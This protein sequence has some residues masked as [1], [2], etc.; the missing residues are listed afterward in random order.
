MREDALRV[1]A[2]VAAFT[3][4][5]VV[6]G[7]PMEQSGGPRPEWQDHRVFA[8]NKL[9]PR[10]TM[11]AYESEALARGGDPTASRW[12]LSLN[13]P[14]KFHWA[15]RPDDAPRGHE[16]EDFDDDAWAELP[17]PANWEV[18]GYGHAI[19]L[20]E[21]YPFQAEWP[22]V[23]VDHNP[24]GS[25]RRTFELDPAWEGD[26]VWLRFG[27]V[28]S[29]LY[30]WLNGRQVGYSQGAKTPAS[31]TTRSFPAE[32]PAPIRRARVPVLRTEKSAACSCSVRTCA[33]KPGGK[34][35]GS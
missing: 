34:G 16:A 31:A 20:D 9:A 4:A 26:R 7:Q 27:G 28:R 1:G 32:S 24:V 12:H 18:H 6:Q 10:A 15:A 21:R 3:A 35:F 2:L 23:P 22:R 14:W 5:T 29:A 30:V 19:Y 11:T 8:V 25:Y 33:S 17:V 13:G